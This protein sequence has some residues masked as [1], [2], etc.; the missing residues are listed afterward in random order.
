MIRQDVKKMFPPIDDIQPRLCSRI[1]SE[2]QK[3]V[4][5]TSS[6]SDFVT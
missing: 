2:A 6:W 1:R 5:E 4:S 3:T